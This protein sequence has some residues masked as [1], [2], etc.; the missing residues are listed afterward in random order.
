MPLVS[1]F[2]ISYA[3]IKHICQASH[4]EFIEMPIDFSGETGVFNDRLYIGETKK[5][6]ETLYNIVSAYLGNFEKITGIPLPVTGERHKQVLLL[7]FY[8]LQSLINDPEL[9]TEATVDSPLALRLYQSVIPWLLMKDII[10]P[11]YDIP[12]KNVKILAFNSPLSDT[13]YVDVKD[14]IHPGQDEESFIFMNTGIEEMTCRNA[15][16]FMAAIDAHSLEKEKV[17]REILSSKIANK[18]ESAVGLAMGSDDKARDFLMLLS[19]WSGM[20]NFSDYFVSKA[21]Q[22]VSNKQIKKAQLGFGSDPM[23]GS[24]WYLGLIEKALQPARGPD[25]SVRQSLYPYIEDLN[26]K[27]EAARKK[28]GRAGLSMEA[29]LRIKDGE[30]RKEDIMLLEKILGANRVW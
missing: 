23:T 4:T 26:R 22:A 30:V 18:L 11:I 9:V 28:K 6:G 20:K 24:W 29:L 25:W 3:I 12:I 2:N 21:K 14:E 10:C 27:I 19:T 16:V 5:I 1:D 7:V 8:Y 17:I 15:Q 13:R